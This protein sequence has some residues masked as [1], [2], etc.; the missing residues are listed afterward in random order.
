[1]I[2]TYLLAY[3]Q[4][5]N[6]QQLGG[7]VW[8]RLNAILAMGLHGVLFVLQAW[9]QF[10]HDGRGVRPSG[11]GVQGAQGEGQVGHS[12]YNSCLF[13]FQRYS[14]LHDLCYVKKNS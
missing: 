10:P 7:V 6:L 2:R 13:N 14:T 12:F 1:M 8:R 5:L 3:I 9:V 11:A 4:A